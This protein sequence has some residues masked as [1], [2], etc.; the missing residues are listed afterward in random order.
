MS[1]R[2]SSLWLA[3]ALALSV[4]IV[5]APLRGHGFVDYDDP[6]YLT[7]NP[8]VRDGLS[9][10]EIAWVFTHTC[11][12]NYHP[13]TWVS[14]MLDVELFGFDAGKH[15]LVSV[16]LHAANAVLCF[17]LLRS[18][19]GRLWPSALAAAVFAL[20]PLRVESVAWASERKDVLCASF[21][22]LTL[23]SYAR[24]ARS[25][26]LGRYLLVCPGLLLA[27]LAKPMAVSLPVVTLLLDFWPLGRFGSASLQAPGI[28]S[29]TPGH[30]G[31]SRA[32]GHPG[33]TH[34]R[35]PGH[36]LVLEKLPLFALAALAALATVLA[37]RSSGSTSALSTLPLGLRLLNA[38]SAIAA[39]LHHFLWPSNLAVFYPHAAIVSR[40]PALSLLVPAL[41]GLV[42]VAALSAVAFRWRTARPYLLVGWLWFLVTL[43]PVIGFVQVGTQAHADRYTYLPGIGLAL[44]LAFGAAELV[45][46]RAARAPVILAGVVLV[47]LGSVTRAQLSTWRDSETLFQHALAVTERNYLAHT[48]LGELFHSR[49]DAQ[50]AEAELRAALAIHPAF[51][52]ALNDLALL[53]RERGELAQA[54]ELLLRARAAAPGDPGP[55]LG[56]GVVELEAGNLPAA[57]ARLEECL[58][59]S[60]REPDALFN[61]GLLAQRDG[62]EAEAEARFRAALAA[63]PRHGD[64]L[65]NLGQVLLART[66]TAEAVETFER[67]VALEPEDPGAHFNLGVALER[68][69]QPARARTSFRRALELAPDFAAAAEALARIDGG[70]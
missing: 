38:L 62:E 65:N 42:V 29:L 28:P 54:R 47:V 23:L 1:R 20:H 18:L 17:F 3:L 49:G 24:Y 33:Q 15:H 30:P 11:A 5:Y 61:L 19:T 2:L 51:A 46:G 50:R 66:R 59:L 57:R 27:L 16:V 43:L 26:S 60:P 7:D 41:A 52:K 14:H 56:L 8:H 6:A 9:W 70:Q 32:G 35:R 31:A 48:K 67:L 22:L 37:Q 68:L 10:R 25:P 64:A 34:G 69:G 12:A 44:M 63:D 39:Y 40:E 58:Q 36:R 55:L 4:A 13:L 53:Q 45:A 21:F